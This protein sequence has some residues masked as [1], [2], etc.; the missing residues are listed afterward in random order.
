M[1]DQEKK[2]PKS[3]SAGF[4]LGKQK[5]ED[6]AKKPAAPPPAA[7]PT[8]TPSAKSAS[9]PGFLGGKAAASAAKPPEPPPAAPAP[10]APLPAAPP[11]APVMEAPNLPLPPP[12]ASANELFA[13]AEK[14]ADQK[15]FDAAITAY[16]RVLDQEP[17]N[18]VAMNNL[19]LVYIE[20]GRL[21]EARTEFERALQVGKEDPEILSNL[22]YV[23]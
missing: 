19:A 6:A 15:Q 11:A 1:P 9:S 16:R 18:V 4:L 2:D 5:T 21:E 20:K 7:A 13:A 23:L 12:T 10:V 8:P 22:G 14:Y 3:Q 17:G